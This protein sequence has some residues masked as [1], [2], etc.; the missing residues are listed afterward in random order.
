MCGRESG[1]SWARTRLRDLLG[2]SAEPAYEREQRALLKACGL[3]SLF[4]ALPNG[5]DSKLSSSSVS[6]SQRKALSVV[7]ALQTDASVLLLD[8]PTADLSRKHATRLLRAVLFAKPEAT[9][10]VTFNR[11]FNVDLFDRVIELRSG[12]VIY[13]GRADLWRNESYQPDKMPVESAEAQ[14][15]SP[16]HEKKLA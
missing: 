9:L 10:L 2:L 14:F 1:A 5:L 15:A 6:T 11:P 4:D 13:D 3:T 12:R 8:N 16:G 7:R